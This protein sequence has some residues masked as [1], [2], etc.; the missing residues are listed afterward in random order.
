MS[1]SIGLSNRNQAIAVFLAAL[2]A[3]LSGWAAAGFPTS[4]I[5]VGAVVAAI[6]LGAGLAI[7]ELFGTSASAAPAT[8]TPTQLTIIHLLCKP[9]AVFRIQRRLMFLEL[10]R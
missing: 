2:V 3:A 10:R 4:H 7:K 1:N 6:L 8:S 5:A 9:L